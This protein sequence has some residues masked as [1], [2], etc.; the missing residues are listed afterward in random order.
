[1]SGAIYDGV[2]PFCKTRNYY[3]SS[4]DLDVDAIKCCTCKRDYPV[5]GWELV[6]DEPFEQYKKEYAINIADGFLLE[7]KY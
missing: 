1:M 2:C 4:G 5:E 6:Y 3:G 7:G